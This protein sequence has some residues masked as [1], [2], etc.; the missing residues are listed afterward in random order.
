VKLTALLILLLAASPLTAAPVPRHLFPPDTEPKVGWKWKIEDDSVLREITYYELYRVDDRE[1]CYVRSGQWHFG[2]GIVWRESHSG[3]LTKWE[4]R[5]LMRG[6]E[7]DLS[8]LRMEG[9]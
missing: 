2:K 5:Q 9:P 7:P 3:P 4:V 8:R 6:E 1:L